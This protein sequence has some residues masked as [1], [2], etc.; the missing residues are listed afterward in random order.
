[1]DIYSDSSAIDNM[2]FDNSEMR[3]FE[4]LAVDTSQ[5]TTIFWSSYAKKWNI[6][7]L[8]DYCYIKYRLILQTLHFKLGY[9]V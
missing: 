2:T 8:Y 4:Y 5:T 7:K 6:N 1:M 9:T 3:T